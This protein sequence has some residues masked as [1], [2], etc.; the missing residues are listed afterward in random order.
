M[1]EK[2]NC[3]FFF[4]KKICFALGATSIVYRAK[5]NGSSECAVKGWYFAIGRFFDFSCS[6]KQADFCL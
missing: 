4:K 6:L 5:A 2:K 1:K 3:F